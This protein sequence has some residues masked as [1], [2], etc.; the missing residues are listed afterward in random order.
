MT[1]G[2]ESGDTSTYIQ[3]SALH[4]NTFTR[5]SQFATKLENDFSGTKIRGG[6]KTIYQFYE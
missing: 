6:K 1:V 3:Y 4:E 2:N 5:N